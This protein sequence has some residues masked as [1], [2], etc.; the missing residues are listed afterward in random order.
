MNVELTRAMPCE[1]CLE[2]KILD[3]PREDHACTGLAHEPKDAVCPCCGVDAIRFCGRCDQSI[4][5][6]EPYTAYPIDR[7]TGAGMTVYLHVDLCRKVPTQTTQASI[8]Y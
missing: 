2:G 4:R 3:Q 7:P 6:D 1:P 8:R 5:R